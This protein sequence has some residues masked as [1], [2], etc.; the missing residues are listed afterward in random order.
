MSKMSRDEFFAKLESLSGPEG[1]GFQR[2]SKG[3]LVI[4]FSGYKPQVAYDLESALL[5]PAGV[6]YVAM[7]FDR[8]SGWTFCYSAFPKFEE[9]A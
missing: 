4:M 6:R 5:L 2:N 7:E 8:M 3:Q 1:R 9:V